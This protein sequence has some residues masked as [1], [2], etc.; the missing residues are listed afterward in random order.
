M[1]LSN[2]IRG[3]IFMA[4]SMAGFVLNDTVMKFT[5]SEISVFQGMLV[6]G[7]FATAMIGIFA[8]S[9]GALKVIP[10]GRDRSTIIWRSIGELGATLCFL[11]ALYQMPIANITAI[12]ASLPL[13]VTFAAA[14]FLGERIG[15]RRI[16]AIIVGFVGVIIIIRPGTEGFNLYA[17][18]AIGA[19]FFAASRD[20]FTR[21]LSPSIPTLLVSFVTSLLITVAGGVGVLVQGVWSPLSLSETCLLAMAA[22]FIF[23]GYYTI[24]AAMRYGEISFVAPFRY[25]GLLWAIA[26]GFFIFGDIPDRLTI[27]GSLIVVGTGVFTFYREQKLSKPSKS[28]S[29]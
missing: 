11:T 21:K 13:A 27:L 15:F 8:L 1:A 9:R 23:L 4:L 18:L 7:L 29:S 26:T 22:G 3:A 2:N 16:T 20:I 10:K 28:V 17:I 25:S 14:L 5:V 12:L 19:V 6:R 24:V